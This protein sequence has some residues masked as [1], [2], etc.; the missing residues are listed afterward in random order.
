MRGSNWAGRP[1]EHHGCGGVVGLRSHL[2]CGLIVGAP[3][4]RCAAAIAAAHA[5]VG[6]LVAWARICLGY[7]SVAGALRRWSA[8][9]PGVS[10]VHRRLLL[11]CAAKLVEVAVAVAPRGYLFE[12]HL[13]KSD[14]SDV[15]SARLTPVAEENLNLSGIFVRQPSSDSLHGATRP[16]LE[17]R[18]LR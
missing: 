5:R 6:V 3:D 11:H 7:V 9:P 15:T 17:R 1:P 10:S 8:E 13:I 4:G 18:V 14:L 16:I 2:G 12:V